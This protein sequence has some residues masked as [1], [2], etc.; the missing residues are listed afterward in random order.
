[1]PSFYRGDLYTFQV[2]L[3]SDGDFEIT[4]QDL[5]QIKYYADDFSDATAWAI[6]IKPAVAPPG[7]AS[8]TALPMQIG[9]Q[10]AIQDEYRAFRI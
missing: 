4:Y 9:P 2:I 7:I 6:G 10:G 3:F 8:F 1:M 5:P